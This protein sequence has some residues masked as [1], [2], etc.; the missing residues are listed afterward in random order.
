VSAVLTVACVGVVKMSITT[1]N[2]ILPELE[3]E[4]LVINIFLSILI[5]KS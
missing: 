4:V 2:M 5:E 3:T 1:I